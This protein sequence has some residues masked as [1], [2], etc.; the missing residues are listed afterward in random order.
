MKLACHLLIVSAIAAIGVALAAQKPE[1][2]QP[3]EP[4]KPAAT[5][6]GPWQSLFDGNGLGKWKPSD[7]QDNGNIE[8]SGGTIQIG[9]G[10]P[11]AG[12]T[13]NGEPPARMNYEIELE[14]MRTEGHDFFCGLTFP[15]GKDPC[16]L[17]CG[18]W[19]GSLVGLSSIDWNDASENSTATST[20]FENKRWYKIRVRVTRAL[21]TAW[22]D[23][24]QFIN[25]ELEGRK[26]G[27]RWEVEPAV[28][29][30]VSTWNTGSA[31]RNIRW[32]KLE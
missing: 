2:K 8:V 22:I 31:L 9:M 15:V 11:M 17:I 23:D 18:G 12:I 4:V 28:P 7:F 19:G 26:I 25:L 14:A 13:W 21:I 1:A 10:K 5:Q 20:S 27:I 16:T 32:R 3:A 30:G 24:E 6:P 29:L